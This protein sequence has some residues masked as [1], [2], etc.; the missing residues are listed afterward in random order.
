M[1]GEIT[2]SSNLALANM[3]GNVFRDSLPSKHRQKLLHFI[4][5]EVAR[6][7]KNFL[8]TLFFAAQIGCFVSQF[9]LM[10]GSFL[11]WCGFLNKYFSC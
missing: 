11:K 3:I 8:T 10:C 2:A 7:I 4:F 1:C 6:P 5:K 9:V